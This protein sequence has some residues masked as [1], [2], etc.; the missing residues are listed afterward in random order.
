M[1]AHLYKNLSS[2]TLKIS[3]VFAS[4]VCIPQEKDESEKDKDI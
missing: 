4:N 2:S 1:R 3:A